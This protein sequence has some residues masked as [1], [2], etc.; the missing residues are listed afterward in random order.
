MKIT[1]FWA[2]LSLIKKL[3]NTFLPFYVCKCKCSWL[4]YYNP[5]VSAI[6]YNA[7]VEIYSSFANDI[8]I[9]TFDVCSGDVTEAKRSI[10]ST[11]IIK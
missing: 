11:C 7:P 9:N 2:K 1:L 8:V 6:A 4:N 10:A 3:S 5:S